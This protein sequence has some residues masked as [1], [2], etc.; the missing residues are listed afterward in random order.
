MRVKGTKVCGSVFAHTVA[1]EVKSV[2]GYI[3]CQI[4]N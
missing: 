1:E 3:K 4:Y 2:V